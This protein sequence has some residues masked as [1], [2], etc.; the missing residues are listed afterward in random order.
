MVWWVHRWVSH[1]VKKYYKNF[2]RKKFAVS[3]EVGLILS[4]R[5]YKNKLI[6]KFFEQIWILKQLKCYKI[7]L[8]SKKRWSSI[9]TMKICL[10]QTKNKLIYLTMSFTLEQD[11]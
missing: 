5:N 3:L 11:K 4:E 2:I 7:V 8:Y 10:N 9:N 6:C 1:C